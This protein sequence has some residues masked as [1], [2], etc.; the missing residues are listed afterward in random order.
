MCTDD[1]HAEL[2]A[3]LKQLAPREPS[4][5]TILIS[6]TQG[7]QLDY[8]GYKHLY[9]WLPSS[10]TLNFGEWGTGSVQAQVWIDVGIKPGIK[11]FT[12]GQATLV[13]VMLKFSDE[14]VP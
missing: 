4:Y 14:V 5:K 9:M 11:L 6:D 3:A 10:L 12:S 7:W 1:Q 13:P 2:L 8:A